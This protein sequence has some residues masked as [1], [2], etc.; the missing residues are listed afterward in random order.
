VL[1]VA[2]TGNIAAGKST[3][4][5]LFR[6]WGATII[7]ADELVREVE[8]PGT[9]VHAAI[10]RRFGPEV[11]SPDG[12]LD[13]AALRARVLEDDASL[14]A[15]NALVHPAVERR[16]EALVDAAW[17]R[18]DRIVVNDIPLLFEVL[19]PD[20]FDAVVLIDAPVAVRR[21][22]LC[23]LR[24]LS[25]EDADRMIAAQQPSDRKRKKSQYVIDNDGTLGDLER[26]ARSVYDD[27][28]RRAV[29][30]EQA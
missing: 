14:A 4:I 25:T 30:K 24:G 6:R 13:R 21:A 18:G 3:V 15:L 29:A 7:D 8:A 17:K 9:A 20:Q 22:R 27:L 10:A 11:L 1:N 23:G 19:D 26:R 2:L 5:A 16:R 12:T 28:E